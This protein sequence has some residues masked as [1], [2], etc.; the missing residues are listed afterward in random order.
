MSTRV[1][2]F[3]DTL[4]QTAP[5]AVALNRGQSRWDRL[6][7]ARP[8]SRAHAPLNLPGSLGSYDLADPGQAAMVA[9]FAGAAGLSGFVVT[10]HP[11]AE[12]YWTGTDTLVPALGRGFGL[13]YQW[14]PADDP[15]WQAA[16]GASREARA[17]ELIASLRRGP[18]VLADGRPILVVD[19]P[20]SLGDPSSTIALLRDAAAEAGLGGLYL[21]AAKAE[22]GAAQGPG[23]DALVDP[24]P[25]AWASCDPVNAPGGGE[26]LEVAAG[27]RDSSELTDRYFIYTLFLIS[28]MIDRARRGKVFPRVFPYYQDWASHP[29]GGATLLFSRS[30]L[31]SNLVS[32]PTFGRFVETGMTYAAETFAPSERFCFL[33]SWNHWLD[34]SQVEPSVLDGDLVYNTLRDA[35]TKARFTIAT[36]SGASH[37]ID[38]SLRRLAEAACMAR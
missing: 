32:C 30:L 5:Q 25:G 33:D 3:F 20:R 4:Y 36:G 1:L 2:A 13:A 9:A 8:L 17:R 11:T 37:A 31:G 29:E 6:R 34:G 24:S 7:A 27:L 12:G 16:D 26:A 38:P 14:C 28:R 19:R 21:I 35:I 10:C 18:A 22:Q 15:W 23:W